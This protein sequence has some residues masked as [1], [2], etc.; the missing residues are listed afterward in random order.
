[1]NHLFTFQCS[2]CSQPFADAQVD[3]NLSAV[4]LVRD[5]FYIKA[6]IANALAAHALAC[7]GRL[8]CVSKEENV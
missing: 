4:E 3:I 7:A 8:T 1:M 6:S 5:F 2:E